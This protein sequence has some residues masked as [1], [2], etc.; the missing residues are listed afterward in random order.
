MI[1][2]SAENFYDDIF[3]RA[4]AWG[5]AAITVHG[6]TVMQRYIGPSNWSILAEIKRHAGD[7]TV[8]GSGDLFSAESCVD[9]LRQTGVDGLSVARGAIGNPWIFQQVQD[10]L[11]GRPICWPGLFE[12][13]EVLAEHFRLSEEV[14]GEK[15]SCTMMRKFGIKYAQLHPFADEVKQAFI[16]VSPASRLASRSDAL[17]FR[18]FAGPPAGRPG[19]AYRM[20]DRGRGRRRRGMPERTA[21]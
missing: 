21:N 14:Y 16:R 2:Q 8:L 5:A 6:R 13:R 20:R 7:R 3:R 19:L 4:F 1:P 18:R 11:A 17:V 15:R 10:V 9:M 12:Q